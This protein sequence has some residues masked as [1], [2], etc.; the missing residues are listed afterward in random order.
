MNDM[1]MGNLLT[2][3]IWT[4]I[5]LDAILTNNE[6]RMSNFHALCLDIQDLRWLVNITGSN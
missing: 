5:L 3:S 2:V 1:L 4:S 6:E